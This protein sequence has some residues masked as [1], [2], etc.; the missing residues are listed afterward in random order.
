MRKELHVIGT[1]RS[2]SSCT[3]DRINVIFEERRIFKA[4]LGMLSDDIAIQ[5]VFP[6]AHAVWRPGLG[7]GVI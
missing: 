7:H 5:L 1:S 6:D 2:N 3:M 4:I